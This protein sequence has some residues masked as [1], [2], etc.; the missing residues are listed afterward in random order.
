MQGVGGEAWWESRPV[1][2]VVGC[3]VLCVSPQQPSRRTAVAT[4]V[5]HAALAMLWGTGTSQGPINARKS[6]GKGQMA[7]LRPCPTAAAQ[8]HEHA[9]SLT[10]IT[11]APHTSSRFWPRC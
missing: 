11:K 3:L 10:P 8:E 2:R 7:G 9:L 6:E 5:C 4:E 1:G